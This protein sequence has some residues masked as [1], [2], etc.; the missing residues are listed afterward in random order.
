[1]VEVQQEA[2]DKTGQSLRFFFITPLRN[3]NIS[4]HNPQIKNMAHMSE[5][6]HTQ[7]EIYTIF[8]LNEKLKQAIN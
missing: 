3:Q 1:M 2:D 6:I 7:K 5:H 4:G 8:K